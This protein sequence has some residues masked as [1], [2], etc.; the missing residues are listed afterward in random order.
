VGVG[1]D[2]AVTNFHFQILANLPD[3]LR[4]PSQSS[5]VKGERRKSSA[6]T[7]TANGSRSNTK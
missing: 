2:E 3:A 4:C 7:P 6:P 5:P 1:A